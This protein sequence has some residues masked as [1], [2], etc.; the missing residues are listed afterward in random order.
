MT[1]GVNLC[2]R[3]GPYSDMVALHRVR[4]LKGRNKSL[5]SPAEFQITSKGGTLNE[6]EVVH[7]LGAL[8]T[9][10]GRLAEEDS[11]RLMTY[12][13]VPFLSIPLV[14]GLFNRENMGA[15]LDK[16]LQCL[17]EWVLFETGPFTKDPDA[18]NTIKKV[19]VPYSEDKDKLAT[20]WGRL[21]HELLVAPVPIL[22]AIRKLLT[23]VSYICAEEYTS[24]YVPLLTWLGR[25][26]ARVASFAQHNDAELARML[27]SGGAERDPEKAILVVNATGGY[28]FKRMDA[29]LF[30]VNGKDVEIEAGK[31]FNFCVVDAQTLDV[32]ACEHF[33]TA[34]HGPGQMI[35]WLEKIQSDDHGLALAEET[36]HVFVLLSVN[37]D[38]AGIGGLTPEGSTML[39]SALGSQLGRDEEWQLEQRAGHVLISRFEPGVRESGKRLL[40]RRGRSHLW[41]WAAK[42]LRFDIGEEVECNMG[43][44]ATG[45]INWQRG[46]VTS[47]NPDARIGEWHY[48]VDLDNGQ[49]GITAPQD[50]DETI[51][52]AG[53]TIKKT[54][55]GGGFAGAGRFGWAGRGGKANDVH[56]ER[57]EKRDKGSHLTAEI[58]LQKAAAAGQL[59]ELTGRETELQNLLDVIEGKVLPRLCSWQQAAV[60]ANDL[61]TALQFAAHR[62]LLAASVLR[63]Q[64]TRVSRE[65]KEA[66]SKKEDAKEKAEET[67]AEGASAEKS[68][69]SE[70][71]QERA[72]I[73][74][75]ATNAVIEYMS[76]VTFVVAW[77]NDEPTVDGL[78]PDIRKRGLGDGAGVATLPLHHVF[79]T[80]M[81]ICSWVVDWAQH[82][83]VARRAEL[84]T[85]LP[86]VAFNK[87]TG[88][89]DGGK[90]ASTSAERWELVRREPPMVEL[91]TR[92][93]HTTHPYPSSAA[94]LEVHRIPGADV[95]E[96]YF[97]RRTSTE[98]GHDFV[99]VYAGHNFMQLALEHSG[100][101]AA[102]WPGTSGVPPVTIPGEAFGV[103]FS[104]DASDTSWGWAIT[105]RARVPSALVAQL[106]TK[107][108]KK[109][110]SC[111]SIPTPH[112]LEAA[113]ASTL[114]SV[115][116]A[117]EMLTDPERGP[118][119]ESKNQEVFTPGYYQKGEEGVRINLQCAEV[120]LSTKSGTRMQMPAPPLIANNADFKA[121]FS[122]SSA[123]KYVVEVG[124]STRCQELELTHEGA[125]YRVAAWKPLSPGVAGGAAVVSY[126]QKPLNTARKAECVTIA[127]RNE[128]NDEAHTA[129]LDALPPALVEK[130]VEDLGGDEH[131]A[132]AKLLKAI[133]KVLGDRSGDKDVASALADY[134]QIDM[135]AT[136]RATHT[137]GEEPEAVAALQELAAWG[138]PVL[139]GASQLKFEGRLYTRYVE[140]S[141]GWVSALIDAALP[142]SIRA[143]GH[144]I[145]FPKSYVSVDTQ[146]M[147]SQAEGTGKYEEPCHLLMYLPPQGAEE[148]LRRGNP[149]NWYEVVVLSDRR[150]LEVYELAPLGRS[151]QRRQVFASDARFSLADLP[152]SAQSRG[153][154]WSRGLRHNAGLIFEGVC[155]NGKPIVPGNAA[156]WEAAIGSIVIYRKR[157]P[158]SLEWRKMARQI[159]GQKVTEVE[160]DWFD[161]DAF[162]EQYL[163][164]WALRGLLPETLLDEYEFWRVGERTLRGYSKV[165]G[166]AGMQSLHVRL[167]ELTHSAAQ[168]QLL[169]PLCKAS[170]H[171]RGPVGVLLFCVIARHKPGHPHTHHRKFTTLVLQ[172]PSLGPFELMP[173]DH[174][175]QGFQARFSSSNAATSPAGEYTLSGAAGSLSP[176]SEVTLS[177][178][179]RRFANIPPEAKFF[180]FA[181][182][183]SGESRRNWYQHA[184]EGLQ[185]AVSCFKQLGGFVYFDDEMRVCQLSSI[186]LGPGLHFKRHMLS[187]LEG[188]STARKALHDM[189]RLQ[190][191]T[192]NDLVRCGVLSFCWLGPAEQMAGFDAALAKRMWPNGAFVYCYSEGEMQHDCMFCA[193]ERPGDN[194]D[195]L[196]AMRRMKQHS[197]SA[198]GLPLGEQTKKMKAA[199]GCFAIVRRLTRERE[200]CHVETLIN[201][202]AAPRRSC[203]GRLVDVLT[204]IEHLSH[205]LA[206]AQGDARPGEMT[207]VTTVELPRMQLRFEAEHGRLASLD[208]DGCFVSD[209]AVV[210]SEALKEHL[211]VLD[212]SLVLENRQREVFILL[213][214]YGLMRPYIQACPMSTALVMDRSHDGWRRFVKATHHKLQLHASGSFLMTQSL[215]AAMYLLAVRLFKREYALA[216]RLLS[217]VLSDVPF[218]SEEK[219]IKNMYAG[220]ADDPH[221][222]A[223]AM[224]LRLALQCN[225]CDELPPFGGGDEMQVESVEE[226]EELQH[227]RIDYMRREFDKVRDPTRES[228]P[229][230]TPASLP[231]PVSIPT[232]TNT[233]SHAHPLMNPSLH[234]S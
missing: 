168:A 85:L 111:A 196:A 76:S 229:S 205:V 54:K 97:D 166:A 115:E 102:L 176:C 93:E 214:S 32:L 72:Q 44:L 27:R 120:Y 167:T 58:E 30:S 162:F 223:I 12:L 60:A 67:V 230:P 20:R 126:A 19:P 200:K 207:T 226:W 78:N 130:I 3:W 81:G 47:T 43:I 220:V 131:M 123:Q 140:G 179:H 51:R 142:E 224:R 42:T 62:A 79:L 141:L 37:F 225:D 34:A 133:E 169:K 13:T 175:S 89:T 216:A 71:A 45:H 192:L 193:S 86:L 53:A 155:Y 48:L 202:H 201:L 4:P 172:V 64:I 188:W 127:L 228:M 50:K 6:D 73:W 66:A 77:T 105:A 59:D 134:L 135:N 80:Q 163:P 139:H 103:T 184:Q 98:E 28:H 23:D 153:D 88:A 109:R 33:D 8:P 227:R 136:L 36:Q 11:E 29:P 187:D 197:V 63:G 113:L 217:S 180:A 61:P 152:Q 87:L 38:G 198:Y 94:T 183:V 210:T 213:P 82:A 160:E 40:E 2:L 9:F 108:E 1:S 234:A 164:P 181:Y 146:R 56:G 212:T 92:K 211:R 144:N 74:D 15:L 101:P 209:A 119:F 100:G 186:T 158:K 57:T 182:P 206:W 165:H 222:D 194:T 149:G 114:L 16:R 221:P 46:R 132:Q 52:A 69:G 22:I 24:S 203:M 95:L 145:I 129:V 68:K 215:S 39:R 218:V 70:A 150:Q 178:D 91:V 189:G 7:H 10:E 55:K 106:H 143:L 116:A 233:Q 156:S 118:T 5:A 174:T 18:A 122:R 99:R 191:A 208:H 151:L 49:R 41:K 112:V 171:D 199:T 84:L 117:L 21:M 231:M 128:L 148:K 83:S 190:T 170:E 104:S 177:D 35:D 121:V 31:G 161:D 232:P 137:P 17:L 147:V 124:R 204:R 14:L 159:D 185:N 157:S 25:T 154:P 138:M 195:L 96:L 75:G 125:V 65:E 107:L 110:G 90:H 173:I 219:W 26:A